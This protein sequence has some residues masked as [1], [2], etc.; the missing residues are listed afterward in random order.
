MALSAYS[1]PTMET[2]LGISA[3]CSLSFAVVGFLIRNEL[4]DIKMRIVRLEN[5]FFKQLHKKGGSFDGD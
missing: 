3:V 2:L 5:I 1:L 4:H